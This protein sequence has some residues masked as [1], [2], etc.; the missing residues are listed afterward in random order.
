MT[1]E[2]AVAPGGSRSEREWLAP[3]TFQGSLPV[4]IVAPPESDQDPAPPSKE[5]PGARLYGVLSPHGLNGWVVGFG[6]QSGADA[7]S[8]PALALGA[9]APSAATASEA[10]IKAGAKSIAHGAII[11]AIT[12]LRHGHTSTQGGNVRLSNERP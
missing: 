8:S 10:A 9:L 1:G 3:A 2:V 12:P 11:G 6:V 7:T 4:T 5:P